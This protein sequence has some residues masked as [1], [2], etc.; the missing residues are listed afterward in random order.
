MRVSTARPAL[1]IAVCLALAVAGAL[2]TARS[3]TFQTS[4]VQL[5]PPH[6]PYV[7]R[8]KEDLRDF[9][10]LNDILVVVAA[11]SVERAKAYADRLA[12]QIKAL[13][14][15]GRVSHRIDPDLFK[16]QALL[17]L[18]M[19]RL[20][21]LRDKIGEHRRFIDQYAARPTL[22]VLLDSLDEEIARR[23]ALGF[24]DLGLDGGGAE[25][26]DP[27]FIDALLEG[28]AEGLAGAGPVTVPWTRVFTSAGDDRAGYFLSA[29]DKL[30]FILVEPRRDA[31]SFTDN[32]HFIAAIRRTI[33]SLHG[34]YADVEAGATGA[35]A[36]SNDEMVTAFH[37]S[38]AA[39]VLAFALTLALLLLVFRRVVEPLAM[40]GV[41]LVSLAWS[42][43]IVTATVGHLTV[44]S[45][46][47][48]SL[49]LG[50]GI[51]YGIYVLFRYEEELGRGRTPPEA[52]VI[53]AR[54]TGPGVLVGALTAAGAFGVLALT[55]FRGIREFGFIA[56]TA[57]LMAFL[58]MMT[59]FPAVLVTL[60]RRGLARAQASPARA[61]AGHDEVPALERV[62]R[63]R[64]PI[65]LTAALLTA[66]SLAAIPAV[67]FD[68]NRL[69]LQARG[70]ES[71]T[72]ERRIIQSRRSGF[73]ALATADSL[74]E[75]RA[76]QEAFA[77]LPE[78]S[79]V[80]SVLK[81]VP[82]DQD[83]KIAAIRDLAPLVSRIRFGRESGV[84]L[85]VIRAAL[86]RLRGRLEVA[87]REAEGTRADTLR[88]AHGRARALLARLERPR[89]DGTLRLGQIQAG[90]RD[91][92]IAKVERLREN[93][94]PRPVTARDLPDE[95]RRKFVAANGRLLMLIYPSI[96][97]WDRDGAR[98]F[99][100]RLRTVDPAV[101]GSP[102][103]SYEASR[104]M[105][106][107]YFQGTL[108]AA[109]LVA[110][111][112]A[113]MLRRASDALLALIPLALGTL[114]TIGFMRVF[115][116]SFNLANVWGLPL[117]IGTSAEYGLNVALRYR[118]QVAG[119]RAAF[120]RSTV[121]A[122][123]LNGLTTIGGFGSLMLA[124]HQGI[125]G[126]GLLLT[127]GAA[128]SLA[129]SLVVLP[130]LLRL[131]EPAAVRIAREVT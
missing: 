3:L 128:A 11:P 56:G 77:R 31:A 27:G 37:D 75:L 9:G 83:A 24:I 23:F 42:L 18:S 81:L 41:L 48:V 38:T 79:E 88:S 125:F 26:F 67:R 28:I 59:F 1:T 50:I 33:Q 32:A 47:F 70:T 119:G 40:L 92:F 52:L 30:L 7:Q 93:L 90:L 116:L 129:T 53:M 73:P 64:T 98:E 10:E 101:T 57:I 106:A 65:L 63:R 71:V 100:T 95:L 124:R 29:D 39:T 102:V 36:L 110:A 34:E 130:V 2:Y 87:M 66:G 69:N 16:G 99:V 113:V 96:D 54:R 14:G 104:L 51:D 49:L 114:W 103:I 82:S 60:R 85:T 12:P 55:E 62:L 74:P 127:V 44:F 15:A 107:A 68:Y 72:W 89:S 58:A 117:I 112:A 20:A 22:P 80:M 61:R 121:M 6:L 109:I 5:L 8:F 122:V 120:P 46:M 123:V 131:L 111:L 84:D 25:R 78:V 86:E 108:Y 13:P 115:G 21:E 105:E 76:K 97:T 45:V 118:E 94:A 91:D 19:D 17:Y 35:P 43:A 4:A 126:L